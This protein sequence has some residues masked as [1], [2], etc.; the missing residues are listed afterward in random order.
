MS[1]PKIKLGSINPIPNRISEFDEI[2]KQ[3][4]LRKQKN[5]DWKIAIFSTL[6][7]GIMGFITSLTFWLLS[8]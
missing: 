3:E 6:C 5:H 8:K 7:G 4:E 2:V 1:G